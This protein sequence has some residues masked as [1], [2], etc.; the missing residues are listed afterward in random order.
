MFASAL[1]ADGI[2]IIA[3][4]VLVAA[5]RPDVWTSRRP[6]V[7]TSE[8]PDV[9]TSGRPGVQSS[10]RLD[11]QTSGP[12]D[13]QSCGLLHVWTSGHPDGWTS[14]RPN[15]RTSGRPELREIYPEAPLLQSAPSLSRASQLSIRRI[16][17]GTEDPEGS[18]KSLTEREMQDIF[19]S[20]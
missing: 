14:E 9:R 4:S 11:I 5:R 18:S 19:V 12:P 3:V 16:T 2:D 10:Q 8:R 15:V 6:D 17:S 1:H 7:R 20:T 13:V